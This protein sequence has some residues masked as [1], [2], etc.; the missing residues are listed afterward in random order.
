M[1]DTEDLKAKLH[2]DFIQAIDK[3][4]A[5]VTT[6]DANAWADE[7]VRIAAEFVAIITA[8][9]QQQETQQ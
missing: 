2:E 5:A 8:A 9:D 6:A 7:A 3:A 1:T 4:R